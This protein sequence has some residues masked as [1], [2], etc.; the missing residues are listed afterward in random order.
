MYCPSG[1]L[2][3]KK[4]RTPEVPLLAIDLSPF[5]ALGLGLL[6]ITF[7]KVALVVVHS[8]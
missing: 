5:R 6:A 1:T 3:P 7:R 2:A 4:I 8:N